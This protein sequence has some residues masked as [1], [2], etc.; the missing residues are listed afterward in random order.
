MFA[1]IGAI[2]GGIIGFD[3]TTEETGLRFWL[4]MIFLIP[5][6][7]ISGIMA[8][9]FVDLVIYLLLRLLCVQ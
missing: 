9:G 4:E 6:A 3:L 2:V 7:A 1:I 5:I 8:G